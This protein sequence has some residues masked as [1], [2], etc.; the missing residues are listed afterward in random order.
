METS[1]T[2]LTNAI[3]FLLF[4]YFGITL[5]SEPDDVMDKAISKAY[6][7]ATRQGAFNTQLTDELKEKIEKVKNSSGDKENN[8][9]EN[10]IKENVLAL[11]NTSHKNIDK[12][13][14]NSWHCS[15]CHKLI[16]CYETA[17]ESDEYF[18][19]GNAQKWVNMTMKYLY[20]IYSIFSVYAKSNNKFVD[21]CGEHIN[22]ISEFLHVPVDSYIIESVWDNESIKL[23]LNEKKLC[24]NGKRGVYNSEKVVAWSKWRNENGEYYEFQNTL[25]DFINKEYKLTPIDWEGPAWIDVA[26]KRKEKNK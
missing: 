22:K 19:Y 25:N 3:N 1:N 15:L 20:L 12:E 6:N 8:L 10:L 16:N 21:S 14:F 26:I 9:G 2:K 18:T 13:Y 7:D 24:K 5:E 23:P 11:I 4:S 17:L